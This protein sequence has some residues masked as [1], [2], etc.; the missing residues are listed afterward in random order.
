MLFININCHEILKIGKTNSLSGDIEYT[1]ILNREEIIKLSEDIKYIIFYFKK[2]KKDQRNNIY[3][4]PKEN[5]A[6]NIGTI[7]K[8]PLFGPNKII[9][10]YD[11]V[12]LKNKLYVKI[13]CYG[14]QKCEEEIFI[15]AYEQLEIEEGETF[16]LNGYQENFVYK[17]IY[18][19]KGENEDSIIK[20]IS[21]YS[22]QKND[23]ELN[24]INNN[25]EIKTQHIINGYLYCIKNKKNRD[26]IYELNLT[27]RKSSAYVIFQVISIDN[28]I[29][30]NNI[31][32]IRPIIGI[33]NNDENKKCFYINEKEE[34]SNDYLVD[35]MIEDDLQALTFENDNKEPIN[36]LFSQTI[37]FSSQERKFCLKKLYSHKETINFYFTIHTPEKDDIFS[38]GDIKRYVVPKSY[39]G[40]LYNGYFYKKMSIENKNDNAYYPADCNSN[41][42][43]FYI[44]S[45][46]GIIHVSNLVTNNFP[47]YNLNEQKEND[48][49]TFELRSIKN[50]GNEYFGKI[51][52]KDTNINSS[53]MNSNKNIISIK[54]QSGVKFPGE[55]NSYCM[56]NIICYSENDLL[57]LRDNEKFSYI[58]YGKIKLNIQISQ[59]FGVNRNKLIID[60]YSHFGSSYI[61]IINKDK[62]SDLNTF[63][64]G[65]LI[66][67]EIVYAFQN[68]ENNFINYKLKAISNDYDYVS[69]I[70]TGNVDSEENILK[71]RFWI[72]DYIL[73]TLTKRIPRK[74]FKIDHIPNA[75]TD[76]GIYTTYFLFKYSNCEVD[77]KILTNKTSSSYFP[78][79][80]EEK[81]DDTQLISFEGMHSE[82]KNVIEFEF[83]LK[84]IYN[85]E[86]V[87]M[88]Y[89]AS[90]LIIDLNFD[91]SFLY[92]ILIK[93]NTDTPILLNNKDKYVVQL[94]YII[95][96]FESPIIISVSF[97]EMIEIYL[98][99]SM[100]GSSINKFN[101]FYSQNIIIYKNEIK[102]KCYKDKNAETKLCKLKIEIERSQNSKLK[103]EFF[104]EKVLLNIKIKSN[105]ENHVSY[106]NLNKVT[107][108]MILGDQFQYYYTNLRQYDTGIISLNNKKGLGVMYA[109]IINKNT[110]DDNIN[111][112]WNGRIHLL[113]KKELEK[114]KDCLIYNINTNE[115]IISEEDTKD[116]ISD[117]RCQIIIGI[118]NI[119]NKEDDNADEYSV[120]EYSIYFLKNNKK[121]NIFG[122]LKIQSNKYIKSILYNN[123]ENKKI[124]EYYLPDKVENIKYELQCNSCS[125]SLIDSGRKIGQKI[126]DENTIKNYGMNLI[127]FPNEDIKN[128]YNKIIQFEFSSDKEDIIFFR[129]SPLFNGMVENKSFLTSEMNSICY[130]ECNYLIPIYDY[131][132]LTSLTMSV[133]DKNLD[134]KINCELELNIYDSINY[135][136]YIYFKNFTYSKEEYFLNMK[137]K[138]EKISSKKNYIVF[139]NNNKYNNMIILGR[140]KIK[141]NM[142]MNNLRSFNVYYTYSKNSRKN[143]FLYPNINNLLFINKNSETKN[144]KEIRIPDY[145]LIKDKKEESKDFSIITFSHIKGEGVIELTTNNVYFHNTIKKFYSELKSFRF[146]KSHSFF[147]I[148][149]NQNSNFSKTFFVNSETGLYTY[150]NIKTNL[151]RNL[152][153]IKLGK[154]NYILNTYDGNNKY[155]YIKLDNMEIIKNDITVDIKI[156]GL[157]VYIDYEIS[158]N[159][160]FSYEENIINEKIFLTKGFYDNIT[161]IGIVKFLS[162]DMRKHYREN[163]NNILL[164]SISPNSEV[165]RTLDFMI[166][167]TPI[168]SILNPLNEGN[169]ET[170]IPQYEH[171][172][173]YIDTSNNDYILFKLNIINTEHHF[174]SIE[175]H[176]L[177][178]KNTEFSLHSDKA[179][180]INDNKEYLFKNESNKD[181]F[182]IAD[183]RNQD[184]KRSVIINLKNNIDEIY[185]VIF[186]KNNKGYKEKDFFSVKYYGLTNDDY[187][188]GKYLYKKRFSINNKTINFNEKQNILNWEKIQLN[189]LK[190]AKGE[191][192]IDYY[193]KFHNNFQ[194]N[195]II[196]SNKGLFDNY[197]P[198]NNS[199]GI[200][201][202]NKNEYKF[203]EDINNKGN[204]E[205][206]LI[207]KFNELNGME[208]FLLY[209]PLLIT[210]QSRENSN[211]ENKDDK[212][213]KS[214]DINNTSKEENWSIK[215]VFIKSFIIIMIFMTTALIILSVFKFIKKIQIK[216]AYDKY[217]KGNKEDKR[218][219]ALF[220]DEKMPFESKISFLIEN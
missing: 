63:Y 10:P 134:S 28:N 119:E 191:I 69:I 33:L 215:K 39:L 153:E 105:Y 188:N 24:I 49:E 61:D 111:K 116:C 89:F 1:C 217:I 151:E 45:I 140:V 21:A 100:E 161:N 213:I 173:S 142:N 15:N 139:E 170:P 133:S 179:H 65:N 32:L 202:I 82:T 37:N 84:N 26:S 192:K 196:N 126:D 6:T 107:D 35:F 117:V 181:T 122:N 152:N 115:I 114:C 124:Y 64:N 53:P 145:Y 216:N 137:P 102:E 96:N 143:Y 164:I 81:I 46:K 101:I 197:I 135:Y 43:Y 186:R 47:F 182:T 148:N 95:F 17:F 201:L 146:D 104:S 74:L 66:S 136:S 169:F 57:L 157:D 88:I 121:N 60:T 162:N 108:G 208:N 87:C 4:A 166:K 130:N 83:D 184:G 50:I 204:L 203:L 131:D 54:C 20:Q 18:K 220:S 16:Y 51:I 193:L 177:N 209:E 150:A 56:Y 97:E 79:I 31:E 14:K 155:L 106:L 113:N 36:I 141:E 167:I 110:I 175:L 76:I 171:F 132:K 144:L 200:H 165:F 22:Y 190:E 27:M 13:M 41:I 68:N 59:N 62:N 219:F 12:K 3:I 42:L 212:D 214:K 93:E 194:N 205:V 34:E 185:L 91:Y 109:R 80:I 138:I 183:E 199:F 207:A 198:S 154:A 120:Y 128:Y 2:E 73:T 48:E 67:H 172:F 195:N 123:N 98:A 125:F 189:N 174:M 11:Y 163:M 52:I 103:S 70:I 94:E 23:F 218:N 77:T 168:L 127:K 156:E 38:T 210:K 112:N 86:P 72:N 147:K 92:P 30:Y 75:L 99:Y 149:Y 71:T 9:I 118:S 44:Y 187:Q 78:N 58:N 19:Y 178:D 206:Y 180:L 85:N 25:M 159:I 8:L 211:N 5:E 55:E 176:F 29:K 158:I 129:F 40:L 160:Y 7:F 90:Y